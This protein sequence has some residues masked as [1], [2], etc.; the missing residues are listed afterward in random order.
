MVSPLPANRD[1][2]AATLALAQVPGIGAARL[3]TLLAAFGSGSGAMAAP[4]RA[5]A[6]LAGIGPAAAAAIRATSP[7]AGEAILATL[8][9]LGARVLLSGDAGFPPLLREIHD[10]PAALFV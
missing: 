7:A 6:A 10:P 3:R 9:R 8:D 5:L 4:A 2:L 1:E